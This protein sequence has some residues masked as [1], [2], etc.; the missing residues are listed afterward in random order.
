MALVIDLKPNEKVIVGNA[1]ITNDK[2][3]TRLHIDGDAPILREKDVMHMEE[4]DSPCKRIYYTIQGMYL[5]NQDKA[6]ELYDDYFSQI[7][8]IQD[9]APTTTVHFADINAHILS[10]HYYKALKAA[11]DLIAYEEELLSNV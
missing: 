5:A 9:A 3:R 1:V 6:T 2:Q 10:G 8:D 7:R 11:K 4:A